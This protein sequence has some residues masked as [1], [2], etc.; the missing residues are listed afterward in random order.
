VNRSITENHQEV[1]RLTTNHCDKARK[2]RQ[3][4]LGQGSILFM[5]SDFDE[6]L[7]DFEDDAE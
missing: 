5:A 7:E 3:S 4:G 1:A 2:P 6:P